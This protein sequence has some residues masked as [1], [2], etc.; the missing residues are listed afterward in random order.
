VVTATTS[1]RLDGHVVAVTGAAHGLGRAFAECIVSND[2]E[3]GAA[4]VPDGAG[5]RLRAGLVD[6][7]VA[8]RSSASRP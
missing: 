1:G 4:G 3:F 6:A 8:D 2:R 5:E 7:D